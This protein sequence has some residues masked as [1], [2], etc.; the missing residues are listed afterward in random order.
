MS[1][2]ALNKIAWKFILVEIIKILKAEN[3]IF[4]TEKEPWKWKI[5][6]CYSDIKGEFLSVSKEL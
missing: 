1:I 3:A 5:G 4:E 6:M 2:L